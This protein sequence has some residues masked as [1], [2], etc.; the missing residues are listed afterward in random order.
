MN[1]RLHLHYFLHLHHP[2]YL[3]LLLRHHLHH[4]HHIPPQ[5]A[6]VVF[7]MVVSTA[8]YKLGLLASISRGYKKT[9]ILMALVWFVATST[10][11][12]RNVR[13]FMGEASDGGGER[14]CRHHLLH[15]H[16]HTASTTT[17]TGING[18]AREKFFM[19]RSVTDA[20]W[21]ASGFDGAF[22]GGLGDSYLALSG[23]HLATTAW[24][25]VATLDAARRLARS[26][27]YISPLRAQG[28]DDL[29]RAS[30]GRVAPV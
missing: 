2:L 19:H 5:V 1:H 4:L 11:I 20:E 28:G 3:H 10:R 17:T 7:L 14:P 25:Y 8:H 24:Y 18:I 30:Q 12:A 21:Q 29:G 23:V 27:L 6:L 9:F 16:L 13:D 22:P 15:L 26:E